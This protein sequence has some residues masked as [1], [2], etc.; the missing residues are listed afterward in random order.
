MDA[1]L[2]TVI[3][4]DISANLGGKCQHSFTDREEREKNIKGLLAEK[5]AQ[6]LDKHAVADGQSLKQNCRKVAN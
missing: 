2:H 1:F 4:I 3:I 5:E 6:S